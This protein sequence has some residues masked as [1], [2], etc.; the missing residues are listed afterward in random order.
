MNI[1]SSC[2]LGKRGAGV[3]VEEQTVIQK[4][5]EKGISDLGGFRFQGQGESFEKG[6]H[7]GWLV[8]LSFSFF[9]SFLSLVLPPFLPS[10]PSFKDSGSGGMIAV[11]KSWPAGEP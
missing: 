8:S 4:L 1:M 2:H 5:P 9:P 3:G 10:F 7:I 6:L 11:Q